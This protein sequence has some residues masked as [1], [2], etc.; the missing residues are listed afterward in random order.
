[1]YIYKLLKNTFFQSKCTLYIFDN[2]L[3]KQLTATVIDPF[4]IQIYL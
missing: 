3:N 2:I 4:K 1:M